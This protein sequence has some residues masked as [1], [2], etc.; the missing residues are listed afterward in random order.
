MGKYSTRVE[1]ETVKSLN[2][3]AKHKNLRRVVIWFGAMLIGAWLGSFS[4]SSWPCL[5][6][7]SP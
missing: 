4:S 2:K 3:S 1:E 6:S 7:R 5:S